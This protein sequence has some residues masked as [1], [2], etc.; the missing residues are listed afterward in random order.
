MSPHSAAPL[1]LVIIEIHEG[2][3]AGPEPGPSLGAGGLPGTR[4]LAAE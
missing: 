3:Q 4:L 1:T 2:A